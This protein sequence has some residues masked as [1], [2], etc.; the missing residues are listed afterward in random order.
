MIVN[1]ME[2]LQRELQRHLEKAMNAVSKKALEDMY[3]ETGDYYEGTNPEVYERTG[4][5]GDTPRVTS[6]TKTGNGA[7]FDAYLDLNYRYTTGRN[8]TMEDVL[9]LADKGITN[10]SVGRLWR[11]I[12]KS[13]FWERAENKI[14][15]DFN[16]IMSTYFE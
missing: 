3:E 6:I 13:G 5:L 11:T 10:S 7:F 9:N 1:N 14:Q 8:P 16:N 4:A 12:G 15:N 2:Q